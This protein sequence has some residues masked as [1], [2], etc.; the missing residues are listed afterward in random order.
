MAVELN[1]ISIGN[2]SLLQQ[3]SV[4]KAALNASME[5]AEL[6]QKYWNELLE[7]LRK[8]GGGGG[9]GNDNRFDRIAVSMM[10]NNFLSNKI[11]QAILRNFGVELFGLNKIPNQINNTN[12]NMTGNVIQMIGKFVIS[13]ATGSGLLQQIPMVTIKS[14]VNHLIGLAGILSFQ[15]NK[16]K[17]ILEE[18]LKEFI[19]KLDIKEKM[20]KIKTVIVDFFVEMKDDLLSILKSCIKKTFCLL[21]KPVYHEL[22]K[23]TS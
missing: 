14:L 9:G 5:R 11:I 7:K 19:K 3:S 2:R 8:A 17:E 22:Y 6:S 10:L 21:S 4:S 20:R 23:K 12:Q 13:I 16:L 15:M 1:R 18:D